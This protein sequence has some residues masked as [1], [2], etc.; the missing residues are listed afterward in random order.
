MQAIAQVKKKVIKNYLRLISLSLCALIAIAL[1]KPAWS[2]L[3]SDL[4]IP[5]RKDVRIVVI[6]D[7][8]SQYGSTNYEPEVKRAISLIPQL[9][10]DLV[11]LGGDLIAGQKLSLTQSQIKAMWSAFDA[12]L[13]TPLRKAGVPFGLTI[14]NH[15]GSGAIVKN[16]LVFKSER[17]LAA[18]YWK[19]PKHDPGLNFIDRQ[20]FPFYYSF[21]QKGIFYLVWDA[22][23]NIIP[24]EQ[25]A[26]AKQSLASQ[27]AKNAR[28]RIVLGHLPLY[29]V[30]VGRDRLGEVLSGPEQLRS[31]LESYRV[32]TYISGHHHAFF[33]GKKGKLEL[34]HAG[35]LG[36]G[37]RQLLNSNLPARQTL[38]LV[39]ISF[40]PVATIYTTYDM[41]TLKIIDP[42]TLPKLII[43]VNGTT[44][45]RDISLKEI[46]PEE[47]LLIR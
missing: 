43:G 30:A 38:T 23:T 2:N 28:M 40:N 24:P 39:D 42:R 5:P 19:N 17:E 13:A 25:I 3:N 11:L 31:L 1:I 34:L 44:F 10:S 16:K 7:L 4:T 21:T 33:P 37:P 8:N 22:S 41:K 47:K 27:S 35:A 29:S 32:H 18:A 46:S 6:S 36:T 14:G 12:N 9:K 15:D 45:R 20:G 26:W